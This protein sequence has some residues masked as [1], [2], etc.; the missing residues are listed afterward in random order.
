MQS[1]IMGSLRQLFEPR[2]VH[3]ESQFKRKRSTKD[4]NQEELNM[5]HETYRMT[6]K[7]DNPI[8]HCMFTIHTRQ[9]IV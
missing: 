1:K 6:I 4:I 3:V 2:K 7:K 5:E 9:N 8:I